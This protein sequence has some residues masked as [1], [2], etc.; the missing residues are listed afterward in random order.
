MFVLYKQIEEKETNY[1]IVKNKI[2]LNNC[3]NKKWL[4]TRVGT[5]LWKLHPTNTS[6]QIWVEKKE[7][8]FLGHILTQMDTFSWGYWKLKVAVETKIPADMSI[9]VW[10]YRFI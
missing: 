1:F 4:Y 6:S 3:E 10:H 8:I 9:I 5:V 7:D 2:I